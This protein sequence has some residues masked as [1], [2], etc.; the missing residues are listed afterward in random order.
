ML[1]FCKICDFRASKRLELLKHYRLKHL[2]SNQGHSLPCLY[3]N[4]HCSFKGWGALRAHL[5]RDHTQSEH[6]GQN[7]FSCL[8][9]NSCF[10]TERQYFEHLGAHLKKHETVNCVFK[11]CDYSTNIYSTFASHKSRKHNPHC[12]EDFKQ[13]VLQ[14]Y[15]CQ[16][17]EDNLLLEE[18]EVASEKPLVSESEDVGKVIVDQLCS[19]FLKLDCIFNVPSRCIDEIVDELRF[20]TCTAS[21]PVVSNVVR[22]TLEKYNCTV[23][24]LAVTDLVNGICELNPVSAALGEEG[25]LGTAYQRNKYVKELFSI[26]E[27]LEYILDAKEGKTFQYVPIL[28]SLSQ[29][30][31]NSDIQEK[32]FRE[33]PCSSCRY[34][35]FRDGSHFQENQ[36]LSGEE[37]RLSIL[38]YSDDFEICNPL[39]TSRKKHKVTS[40]YWVLADIPSVLRSTLSSIYLAVLCKADDIKKFGYPRVLEPLLN[41][42]KS[43]EEE[44]LFVPCLG[45]I[46]KGT[47]F[48]VIADNLGAHSVGGFIESFSASY[49][50]RFCIGERSQFQE[51]EVRTGAFPSRTKHH[52]QLDVEAALAS[53]THSHGVKRHCAI[54]E[55]L[56]HFHVTT[57]YPPDILHDLLEGI[58]PVELALCL[59]ILIKKKYFSLEELNCIIQR[60]PYKWKDRTNC[61]QVIPPTFALRKTIGGNAHENWCLLRLLPFM[62]GPKIP[63]EEETWQLLMTL[64][65]VVELVMS[66]AHTDESI[67]HL[68]SLIA[69]HRSR[70]ISAF[71]KE[72]LIPKHHF[73]EHYPGLIKAFGPL[74]SLWTM[75]FEAKHHFFKKI[76][77]HTNC[78]RNILK[79]MARKHQ[80]MIA[81]HLHG[82][83][84][85]KRAVSVSSVSRVPLQ[86]VHENIQEFILQKFPEEAAVHFTSKVEFQGTSYGIG[87]MLVY[88]STG[89]LPDFAEILQIIVV[90]DSLVF[91]V[92]LHS[93]WY[94]EHFRCFK[95]ESTSIV[96]VIDQ[97]E[98]ADTHPLAAYA[99]EGN[100]M[101]SLKH[102]ICLSN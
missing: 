10:H 67:G 54:S 36:F 39:G 59:D 40:V 60:F 98:L 71:P 25:P 12:L 57:G 97:S 56:S 37:L 100:R 70:F 9:C 5:S 49:I 61:P 83:N 17:T 48:S 35:S 3:S 21:A 24:E 19:L 65:D 77:R 102:H 31:K 11:D 64:K 62:I 69:E 28:Q 89:G 73:V 74:V 46:I 7:V 81:Y 93:A 68:D 18:S 51:L 85:K 72:K 4:C 34:N 80:C 95:L 1:W 6:L 55:R 76:V 50:C 84:V 87:M 32:V 79:T 14:T 43:F 101:V 41:D 42:L 8:I 22:D 13:I 94:F 63:E 82:L 75:R 58:V 15:S 86:V 27:P 47:V 2:H 38:L 88:R 44:G 20:I 92:K 16:A 23:E 26:V 45:K 99:V 78:F 90:Q 96:K 53:N 33:R 66:P 30:L 52:H 29:I 91:V